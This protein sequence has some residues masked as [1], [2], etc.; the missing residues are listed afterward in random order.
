MKRHPWF[1]KIFIKR[2]G[3]TFVE[4]LTVIGI[5]TI[6]GLVVVSNLAGRRSRI[7]LDN[8]LRQIATLLR[9]AQSRSVSQASGTSWGVHLENSTTT[10][11]FFALFATSYSSSTRAGYYRLPSSVRYATSSIP[12]GGSREVTFAQITGLPSTSTSITLELPGGSEG[13]VSDSVSRTSSGK[14]FFDNFN[15]SNL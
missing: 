1:I 15:R 3:Y 11:P 13:T 2:R 7:E 12:E 8:T 5:V 4:I 9:E 14:I 6:V 10:P